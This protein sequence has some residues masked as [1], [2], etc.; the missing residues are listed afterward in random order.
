MKL[1]HLSP[2]IALVAALT[3]AACTDPDITGID[4]L[5][6]RLGVTTVPGTYEITFHVTGSYAIG[7]GVVSA[8]VGTELG[9]RANVRDSQGQLAVTG[10]VTF[11][12]CEVRR[13]PAPVAA[14]ASGAGTWRR[15]HSIQLDPSGYPPTVH[16]GTCSSP[17]VI[18]FRFRYAGKRGGIAN[19]VSVP[20]DFA[21]VAAG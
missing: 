17:T 5:E 14:C 7:A 13:A 20:R 10:S 11:E 19:G 3:L 12:R 16:G 1:D 9:V 18:G 8:P 2:R 21:W 4:D 15:Y 6:A